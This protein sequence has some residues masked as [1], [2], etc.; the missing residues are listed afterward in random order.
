MGWISRL[1]PLRAVRFWFQRRTRGFDDSE[2]WSLDHTILAFA[3]PRLR[4]FREISHSFPAD[5]FDTHPCERWRLS[6][7]DA[8]KETDQGHERWLSTIKKMERAIELHLEHDG[9]FLVRNE[10]G[11]WTECKELK[12]EFDEGWDLFCKYF[13]NLWD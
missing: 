8:K 11:R 12:A 10:A 9:V 1:R 4:R 5:F 3:L 7:E 2:L 13:F 6:G